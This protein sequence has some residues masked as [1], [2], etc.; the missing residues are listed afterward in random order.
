[1]VV[2]VQKTFPTKYILHINMQTRTEI[3]DSE[4]LDVPT[5]EPL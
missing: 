1:M 3:A 4:A 2:E 5:A